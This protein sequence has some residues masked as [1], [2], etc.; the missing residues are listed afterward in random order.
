[1][2]TGRIFQ[3]FGDE[4]DPASNAFSAV[5]STASSGA[6]PSNGSQMRWRA[7]TMDPTTDQDIH[8]HFDLPSNYS[9]GG[10]LNLKFYGTVTT[11]NVIFKT[12]WVLIHP[13]SEGS[14]T[15]LDAA[16]FGTVTVA[17][18]QAVP[19]TAGREKTVALD[20]GV[21][22]AH[23]GDRLIVMLGRDADNASDTAAATVALREPWF[24]SFTTT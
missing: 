2:G 15:D 11:G 16:S 10:T 18:A 20:L 7:R 5:A 17:A 24:L 1:M 22:G 4:T 21:T 6:A 3:N 23:G 19:A 14:P 8:L 9:S 13:S 12:A